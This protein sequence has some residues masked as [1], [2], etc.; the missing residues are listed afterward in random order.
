MKTS[1]IV[2]PEELTRRYIKKL[3]SSGAD[4]IGIH[5][6]GGETAK[7]SLDHLLEMLEGDE[8]PS[9]LRYASELGLEIEYELH[10]ASYLLPREL[11]TEHPEYFRMN[12]KGERVSDFN[13]CV[14][15][16]EALEIYS[17]RAAA[18]A[19]KL[20]LSR[21]Y[22]YLWMDDKKGAFCQCELCKSL[23]PSD[24]QLK[25]ANRVVEKLRA[26]NPK[27]HLAY[28]AY[29]E[30]VEPPK[31]VARDQGIFLEYAPFEKYTA[32]GADAPELI[33]REREALLPLIKLFGKKNFKV[34]EY[35]YDNSMLSEW[36]KPPKKFTLDIEAMR[37]DVSDFRAIGA[38]F[39]AS[40]ACFLGED[41]EALYGE[42]D[43]S[44]LPRLAKSKAE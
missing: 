10:S 17:S 40:F 28:L 44:D 12:D 41:Y 5:P 29:F 3:Y 42:V 36:K 34:L 22:Y 37:Q 7:H 19:E 30:C 24:Q 25:V 2:H 26:K 1:L 21:P 16:E 31:A 18:L 4:I 11:F 9:L 35:W 14:S 33:K 27:A 43:L 8:L 20:Y 23:T 13:F 32:K 38:D 6:T 39:L 15:S